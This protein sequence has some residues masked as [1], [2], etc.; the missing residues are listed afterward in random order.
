MLISKTLKRA[1]D[2]RGTIIDCPM[3]EAPLDE[4]IRAL[5]KNNPLFRHTKLY[6][7]DGVVIGDKLIYKLQLPPP[8]SKG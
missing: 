8:K 5:S 7:D 1:F 2:V 6:E 4:A 3:P